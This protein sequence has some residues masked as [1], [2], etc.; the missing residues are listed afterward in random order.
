MREAPGPR[1]CF[2]A[3]PQIAATSDL[4]HSKDRRSLSA[5][6][7][8]RCAFTAGSYV[9]SYVPSR[10]IPKGFSPHVATTWLG[11]SIYIATDITK[12]QLSKLLGV[13]H[14]SSTNKRIWII[15]LEPIPHGSPL[16]NS[17]NQRI[18]TAKLYVKRSSLS[19]WSPHSFSFR[20]S[21]YDAPRH[22]ASHR[23]SRWRT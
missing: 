23:R 17:R 5:A 14:H 15:V 7:L 22:D 12:I 9:T 2:T 19:V 11:V 21:T 6:L 4:W 13:V 8:S 20:Q 3:L 1:Q 16:R 18:R 10:D